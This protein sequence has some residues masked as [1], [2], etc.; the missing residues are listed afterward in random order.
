MVI[1][2]RKFTGIHVLLWE[3]ILDLAGMEFMSFTAAFLADLWLKFVT[4]LTHKAT[5]EQCLDGIKAFSHSG[6]F[7]KSGWS[8]K[9]SWQGKTLTLADQRD[10]PHQMTSWSAI[11]LREMKRKGYSSYD[12]CVLHQLLG[13]LRVCF[14]RTCPRM[15]SSELTPSFGLLAYSG[16]FHLL[17]CPYLDTWGFHFSFSHTLLFPC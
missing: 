9:R 17:N 12:I 13:V 11:K 14:I 7:S 3:S 8:H 6:P 15:E 5:V 4:S 1:L 2:K 10:I 16:F